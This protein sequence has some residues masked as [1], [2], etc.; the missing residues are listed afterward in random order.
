[1]I[2]IK[3]VCKIANNRPWYH[4]QILTWTLRQFLVSMLGLNLGKFLLQGEKNPD[5]TIQFKDPASTHNVRGPIIQWE[6]KLSGHKTCQPNHTLMLSE[7]GLLW[8]HQ[9][10]TL[11]GD[12]ISVFTLLV[13]FGS[14]DPL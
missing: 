14:K 6:Y 12:P 10:Y 5:T 13:R 1:M 4:G 11:G 8:D 2:P 7:G 3:V 9:H